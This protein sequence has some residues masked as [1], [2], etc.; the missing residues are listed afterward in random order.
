[1]QSLSELPLVAGPRIPGSLFFMSS[2]KA[3]YGH[4]QQS[5][6]ELVASAVAVAVSGHYKPASNGRNDPA[7]KICVSRHF[8]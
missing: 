6:S 4:L 1:M 2:T 3:A 8:S 5:F 7:T